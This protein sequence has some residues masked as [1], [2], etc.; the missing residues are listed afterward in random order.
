MSYS[1][2]PSCFDITIITVSTINSNKNN[3]VK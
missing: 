1:K 2:P 3:Y